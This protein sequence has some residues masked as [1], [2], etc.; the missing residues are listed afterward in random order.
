MGNSNNRV[1]YIEPDY[2]AVVLLD[3]Q[4]RL[5]MHDVMDKIRNKK[6]LFGDVKK[7][8]VGAAYDYGIEYARLGAPYRTEMEDKAKAT[9]RSV[10][11]S[12]LGDQV[13]GEINKLA[14]DFIAATAPQVVLVGVTARPGAQAMKHNR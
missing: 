9:F 2:D 7:P 12:H 5:E 3:Q 14:D 1:R 13:I 11:Q 6:G 8:L 10:Y 4:Y